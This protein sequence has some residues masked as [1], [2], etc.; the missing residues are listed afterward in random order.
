MHGQLQRCTLKHLTLPKLAILTAAKF[1]R[2]F[3][4]ALKPLSCFITTHLS[5][6][7]LYLLISE[8]W[9]N[10][11][12]AHCITGILAVKGTESWSFC[13]IQLAC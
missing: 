2:F 3:P 11:F 7:V 5:Q 6:I 10:V 13:P 1:N 9:N 4:T 8:E 12:V